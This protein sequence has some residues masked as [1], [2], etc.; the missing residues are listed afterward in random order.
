M[1]LFGKR[2][3]SFDAAGQYDGGP[4]ALELLRYRVGSIRTGKLV[5]VQEVR[6]PK[7]G[8]ANEFFATLG[9]R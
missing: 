3:L 5:K 9:A 4:E 2:G 1:P 7:T 8:L 6:G